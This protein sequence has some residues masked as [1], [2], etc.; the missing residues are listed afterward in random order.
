MN[1]DLFIT[2]LITVSILSETVV[3]K[4]YVAKLGS[5]NIAGKKLVSNSV[6]NKFYWHTRRTG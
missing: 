2:L 5:H 6:Q 3:L 1:H 4:V